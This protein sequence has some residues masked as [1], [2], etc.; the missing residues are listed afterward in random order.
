MSSAGKTPEP[1]TRID[2]S[3]WPL[4]VPRSLNAP[5]F[6]TDRVGR[7]RSALVL[8]VGV[9]A[10]IALLGISRWATAPAMV[11]ACLLVG[12][13]LILQ[14]VLTWVLAS[15]VFEL[16]AT[17]SHTAV[18]LAAGVEELV[19]RQ[20][21]QPSRAPLNLGLGLPGGSLP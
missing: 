18:L 14:P 3:G 20:T 4:G 21:Q 16:P 1:V 19:K 11:P 17:L 8:G 6:S 10:L 13:K 9:L 7:G 5:A 12:F 15:F 2:G